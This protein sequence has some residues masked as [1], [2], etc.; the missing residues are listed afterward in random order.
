MSRE[1]SRS[2]LESGRRGVEDV[3][4]LAPLQEGM[5]FASLLAPASG[6][7]VLQVV[8]TLRGGLDAGALREAWRQV[9][10][11]QAAL[12][13]S[14]HWEEVEH[15]HQVVHA[16]VELPWSEEDWRG[17]APEAQAAGRAELVAAERRRGFDLTRPP[18]LRLL[19]VRLADDTWRFHLTNHHLVLDGWSQQLL[20]RE[21]FTLY[22]RLRRGGAQAFAP[23]E[24]GAQAFAPLPPP[25]PYGRYIAWLQRRDRSAAERHWR[26]ELA[27]LTAATPLPFARPRGGRTGEVRWRGEELSAA[28]TARLKELAQRARLT[29]NTVVQ[30][31][32]A[33]LLARVAGVEEVV[34]GAVVAGRPAELRGIEATI[35]LFI[36]S[37][38]LRVPVERDAPLLPWLAEVQRRQVA[39]RDFE[40]TPLTAV[41]GWSEV[42]R[43]EPLFESLV[44]YENFPVDSS[45]AAGVEGVEV[46]DVVTES[47]DVE[48]LTLVAWAGERLRLDVGAQRER[49][50]DVAVERV[51]GALRTLLEG[52]AADPARRL[53]DL[54]LLTPAERQQLREWNDTARD[55]LGS[56]LREL[57]AA[58]AARTPDAVA[59]SFEGEELTYCALAE[60]AGALAR[61]LRELGVGPEVPVG[62]CAERSLELVV[63]LLGILG[64][65]GAYVPL[66]PSYPSERL[67]YLM[68]DSRVAVL[69]TQERLLGRP[70]GGLGLQRENKELGREG[71]VEERSAGGRAAADVT[72][73]RRAAR[74]G[75]PHVLCLDGEEESLSSYPAVFS[76]P[77][78]DPSS[79]AYLIYTSGSTGK[80]KGAMN[81]HRG[82][83]NRLLWMQER[84]GLTAEDRVLQKTPFSFDVSVW[85]FFWP[86]LA[87]AR[88]VMARPGGH[89]DADYLVE[90]IAREGITT[91][92]FV[93]SMLRAF[94]EARGVERCSSLRRVIASGEALPPDL[95]RRFFARFEPGAA[96]ALHNLYGPTEAAVDVTHWACEPG[97]DGGPVP[98]GRPVANTRLHLL[99][100]G[101]QPVPVGVPGELS[102]GGVQVGRG[103]WRRPDLTAERFLPDPFAAEPGARLYRTGDLARH[104]PGGAIEF[105][106]RLDHQVKLRGF[107][108]ELGEIEAAL[109]AHP[110]VGDVAVLAVHAEGKE[111]AQ[112]GKRLVAYVV[113]RRDRGAPGLHENTGDTLRT[114][115]AARLPEHMVPSAFVVLDALPLSPNGKVDRRALARLAVPAVP[116]A[117]YAAPLGPVEELVA[118]V[119]AE[120]LGVERVGRGDGFFALGGHSLLAMRVVS[121][122]RETLGVEL[123]LSSLFDDPTLAGV[124]RRVAAARAEGRPVPPP[125]VRQPRGGDL[126]LSFAQ[127]R[128][129]ILDQFEPGNPAYNMPSAVR[130]EGGLD[131]GALGRALDDLVAR[132]ETLRTTFPVRG[133]RAAPAIASAAA[134]PLPCVDLAALPARAR[135]RELER[136]AGE[137][138]TRPFDLA[139]GPLLRTALLREET[140]SH[141][142]LFTFHHVVCDGWSLGVCVRDLAALYAAA[143]GCAPSAP[144]PDLPVQYADYAVWQRQW[145]AGP[146]RDVQLAY[147][148]R[149]LAGA[150]PALDLP[151][152]RARPA[153][154]THHGGAARR[155]FPAAA[156]E[157]LRSLGRSEGASLFMVLLAALDVLLQRLVGEDDVVVGSPIAGR[158]RTE[159]EGLVGVFLNTL[160]L[161]TSLAGDPTIRE[162]L[163]RVR[164][165]AL[166]AYAHQDVPFEMLL[167]ELKP[168]RDLSR[169]PL[170]QVLLNMLEMGAEEIRLPGLK[171]EPLPAPESPSKFDLTLY[172]QPSGGALRLDA[173]YNRDL[174]D[175]RRI[176]ELLDQ[177][178]L[179]LER[180][181]GRPEAR[182]GTLSLV[183]PAAGALLPDPRAP[184]GEEWHGAVHERLTRH[185]R[186]TPGR[187]AVRDRDGSWTY[188][189]LEARSNRLAHALLAAGLRREE[190]VAIYAHRSA[191]LVWAVLGVLKAGGAFVVLDPAYPAARL[192]ATLELAAPRAFLR[193]T[194]AGPLPAELASFLAARSGCARIDLAPAAAAE[195]APGG[196][197]AAPP[198]VEVGP[199]DLAVIAFTSGSTGRPK[200]ILGRH[201]P[202]S[203]FIP[204]QAERFGLAAADRF[205][206]LSGLAHDPLQRDVFTPLWLGAALA[207]PEPAE[208]A[209]PGRLAQW[210]RREGVTV[211]HLTPAMAQLLTERPAGAPAVELPALRRVF[212]VGDVLTRHDVA[213]LRRLAP[214]ATCVN[215]YGSTETQ[216]AVSYHVARAEDARSGCGVRA[217]EVLPLGR[218]MRDVQ[219]L[220]LDRAGGGLAG[221]GEVGE[222]CVR[223]PHLARGYLG[224]PELTRQRFPANPFTG[225]SSGQLIGQPGDRVYRTGDLGRYRPDGGVDFVA[226]A[227]QQVKIRGFRV[228]PGEIEAALAAHPAVREAV[229]VAPAGGGEAGAGWGSRRL[230]AYVV[231]RGEPPALDALREALGGRLPA[232][233]LPEALVVLEAIPLTPNGKV[234]RRALPAPPVPP[235]VAADR[236]T[237]AGAP[238]GPL[239]ELVAGLFVDALGA[240]P[241]GREE[242]FFALGGNSLGVV[243]LVHA[244]QQ[245]LGE[246]VPMA[247]LFNAPTVARLADYLAAHHGEAVA[248]LLGG[249]AHPRLA[250]EGGHPAPAAAAAAPPI[251]P[252]GWRPGEPVPL[253]FAQERL[254]FLDQMAPGSPAYTIF[255]A[256]RLRGRLDPA[257]LGL[258]LGEVVRRHAA[259][260]T[261]FV[262]AAKGAVQVVAP[263]ARRPRSLA[264]PLVDVAALPDALR[265]AEARRLANQALGRPFDLARGPLL[266]ATLLRLAA[267]GA[268]EPEHALLLAVHHIVSDGWSMGL[269][270][271]EVTALY[272]AFAAGLPSPLPELPLQYPDV[273]LWQRRRLT[274]DAIAGEVA[275]WRGRLAGAPPL[276]DL[277]LDRPR[278][279]VHSFRGGRASLGLPPAV[280]AALEELARREG[281]TPFMALLA[282]WAALLSRASGQRDLVIGTPAANRERAETRDLIGF[283]VNTLALRLDLDGS[284]GGVSFSVLLRR[285]HDTAVEAYAHVELPFERLVAELHPRRSLQHQPL[286]QV[287]LVTPE[288]AAAAPRELPGGF[289]RSPVRKLSRLALA[290]Q[291]VDHTTAKFD[292]TMIA[293]RGPEGLSLDLGYNRDLFDRTTAQRLLRQFASLLAAAVADPERRLAALP[294]LSPAERH[295]LLREWSAAPAV[296]APPTA[297]ET[298]LDLVARSV[299][300]FPDAVAVAGEGV[301]CTYAELAARAERLAR[302]LRRHGVGPEVP[303]GLLLDRS[304]ELVVG[305]LGALAAGGAYLPLDSGAPPERVADL[306]AEARPPVVLTVER[307]LRPRDTGG[308]RVLCL[309]A[310]RDEAERETA[311]Q[312]TASGATDAGLAYLLY[313]SGST[314]R[315]K[316]VMIEH[317]GLS[318]LVERQIVAFRLGPGRRLLQVAAPTFDAAASEVFT[319]LASGATL[320]VA[321][322]SET[323]GPD[324]LRRLRDD[325]IT[326]VTLTPSALGTL[327]PAELPALETLVSAGE[328]CRPEQVARWAPGRLFLNAYGPTE[329]TVC[330]ALGAVEPGVVPTAGRPI[331]G[332]RLLV[333]D[334]DLEP[335]PIGVAG[336]LCIAGAGVGRGYLGRPELTAASFLPDPYGE[337]PGSRQ[338]DPNGAPGARL[339]RTGDRARFRADGEVEILGRL[340]A[341]L[342]VRG[343][344]VEPA[345]VEAALRR[346]PGVREVVVVGREE[347]P[348]EVRLVAYVVGP[349]GPQPDDADGARELRAFLRERLPESLL[350]GALVFL[351]AL[352]RTASGKLDRKAL[353]APAARGA[354][355]T[356][357]S[358]VPRTPLERFLAALWRELL[359]V[360]SPGVDDDFFDLGGDSIRAALLVNRLQQELGDYVYVVALFDAP[361]IALLAAYLERNYP[362]AVARLSG[363]AVDSHGAPGARLALDRPEPPLGPGDVA[364][365]RAL[366]PRR[367]LRRATASKNAPA[368]FV[369]SPPRS[370]STLLRV[371]LAGHPRLFAPPE[372]ELLGFDTLRERRQALSGRFALWREGTV[373]ALMELHRCGMAEAQRR[374]EEAEE[375]DLAVQE[376]YR[377]LQETLGDRLL[378]DKTPS[379]ALAAHT[380]ARAEELFERPL[381]VHLLRHPRAVVRSFERAHLEQVFFRPAHDLPPRRLA[382][383]IWL[384]SHRNV[385]DFLDG[386][387]AERRHRVRFEELVRE[388]R[389]VMERLGR[390]LG[391]G[392]H[393]GMLRPYADAERRMTDGIHAASRMLGDVRFHEHRGIEA[394]AADA[395]RAEDVAAGAALGGPT[396]DVARALGYGEDLAIGTPRVIGPSLLVPLQAAGSLPPLYLVHPLGG[397]VHGY[398]DLARALGPGQPVYGLQAAGLLPGR[399]PH[400]TVEEMA[401]A[402]RD[403][404][405]RHRPH[406]PYRLGGWS[407]GGLVAFEIAR[408]LAARG[409][410]VEALVLLDSLAPGHGPAP[411]PAGEAQLFAALARDL[412]ARAGR[413]IADLNALAERAAEDRWE[414]L[415]DLAVAAGV[416]PAGAGRDAARPLWEVFRAGVSALHLYRPG[417]YAGRTILF[418][419]SRRPSGA[420]AAADLGWRA[421]LA[422]GPEIRGVDADHHA[423]LRPPAVEDVARELARSLGADYSVRSATIGSTRVA[424]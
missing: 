412:A 228:E 234:D 231:A 319:A 49:L 89:R 362:T 299:A 311:R 45:L 277:P 383:L 238:R 364:R 328:A 159:L 200:G 262:A 199:D 337:A 409:A 349:S 34:F 137:E 54:P 27:G 63:G 333:L 175:R 273:A 278:P 149:Q 247:A 167:D 37:L 388:P 318:N 1:S 118:G 232:Y 372:L 283:F 111:E 160:V 222:I 133:G 389:A 20:F 100:A 136:L 169:T 55:Y 223:S 211:A 266:R 331:G 173:A 84:Y 10:G 339:Y 185:A 186:Q 17:L 29:L 102:I 39:A 113:P 153:V 174:F 341:Q 301:A 71:A 384:V 236:A 189:E 418:R 357:P 188:A 82:I 124:A 109:A 218:G 403:E 320:V 323:V 194:E 112:V 40:W 198:A 110:A 252:G 254:W 267:A 285:A 407:A 295:Q 343:V 224:D 300:R 304:L 400:A 225:Q 280:P 421:L 382:E 184:L 420:A 365:F 336:E 166:D 163:G 121:R 141:V 367:P 394:A 332:L 360:D 155:L 193:L 170:F 91:V 202:L 261:T 245:R 85:E 142:L 271:R 241:V 253:S 23:L 24:P 201:G 393:P 72:A 327:P 152:D 12:R 366:V 143:A 146:A 401:A 180:F 128:L 411:A 275:W 408:Q 286:F 397:S 346:H 410:E 19:L 70:E 227:D 52:M 210:M 270:V 9:V 139:R 338:V 263:A 348:G 214:G 220:V 191:T 59:V 87:G 171:I 282:A 206:M 344:R 28:V 117:A 265:E 4:R 213:R 274:A 293:T 417:P 51:L 183:T 47:G 221:I 126:P 264:L 340:D 207:I 88:L 114:W 272:A 162:L 67:G 289:E 308:A 392:F 158:G 310:E 259:L 46:L 195:R 135:A 156:A 248:R 203:H 205:S 352:P 79:L 101:L 390:F 387:P 371:M 243:V 317:G 106:G 378:V 355:S 356:E 209:M 130:L 404:I 302:R 147:W 237:A 178:C 377:T 74:C 48:P 161:R 226:R 105:L 375:R 239:E 314:G 98:I 326:T 95:E 30:G 406:G 90:T 15:P 368:V 402:Y 291:P 179:L 251:E 354:R 18:L 38:P 309:D 150:P 25:V 86:L 422:G 64:A 423:L 76:L 416:L 391:V 294:L 140:A 424:R 13:T 131:G 419:A 297:A 405:E 229:V 7:Y 50:D 96:P 303:V 97:D 359:E 196:E 268:G 290:P 380:L 68:E 2:G 296:A 65:G 157:R 233:M 104:L 57:I 298:V 350:P 164:R 6:A 138:A 363:A 56:T 260:R 204:W 413:R 381:Y 187:L 369:L 148:R 330:A 77:P 398:L 334:A 208:M 129:W 386:V 21:V 190:P 292:L 379:Y 75:V 177:L 92:H 197:E 172:V 351:E 127:E 132:H 347:R 258:A 94:L 73:N 119:W 22:A 66:D 115:L 11:R 215:L 385:V 93:P 376:F 374:M 235:R 41:Q 35:G 3:Y 108:I 353:P 322:E 43:G 345:E 358:A 240:A 255:S 415:R 122:L 154:R 335:A 8:C 312:V 33:V 134:R 176:E 212:L 281:A 396:R 83:V 5:L 217:P 316:G 305:M 342:K 257:P 151:A 315:P 103:Y 242:S 373:R 16:A 99:D 249:D 80:P 361:T 276:L 269:L 325:A 145:L 313:T 81:G 69:L 219:L 36:N 26:R 306:L 44:V 32:W 279:P 284:T 14:F 168:E 62:I 321:G 165:T 181:A 395:W 144:L 399:V 288:T 42:P 116:R 192:V 123:P 53:G 307:L 324:L 182:I 230:V 125:L 256:V 120:I 58:Q 246:A 370:G 78:L 287:M 244:L 329:C 414:G 216:R 60:R 61:R 250:R 107:R 31:A